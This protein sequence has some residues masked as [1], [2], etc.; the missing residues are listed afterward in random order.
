MDDRVA[1]EGILGAIRRGVAAARRAERAKEAAMFTEGR[2]QPAP[3]SE[4]RRPLVL[5]LRGGGGDR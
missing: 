3:V 4:D 2:R 1:E 5:R